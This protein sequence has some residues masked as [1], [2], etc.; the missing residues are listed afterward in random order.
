MGGIFYTPQKRRIGILVKI[1]YNNIMKLIKQEK[2]NKKIVD[3]FDF[4]FILDDDGLYLIEIIASAKSWWQNLKSFKS[5]L[6]DDDLA[7][8]LDRMEISTSSS[9]ETNARSVWHGNELKGF[10]KTVVTAIKL[11]KGKHTLSFT[12]YQKPYLKSI[13]ISQPEETDK[14]TYIP[15]DNNP[16][17]KGNGRPWLSFIL[18]NLSV[19]DL[20][21]SAKANKPDRDDDD[22][23]L[24]IDGETQK[25]S[26]KKSHQDWYWCGKTLKGEKKEFKKIVDY[27]GGMHTI[28]LW[29]DESPFLEKIELTLSNSSQY[30][31]NIIRPYTYK[32]VSGREDYNKFDETIALA[33]EHWNSEFKNDTDPPEK[34]LDP[35]LVKAIIF[36]ESR[37]GYDKEESINIMQVG[38]QGDASLKTLRGKLKEY[39]IHEGKKILLKYPDAQIDKEENS[40]KWGIRWLYHKA[41]GI[42]ADNRRY[43]LTWREAVKKYGPPN[44]KY[45]NNVWDIYTKG[46]DKRGKSPVRLWF[47][48]IP[49]MLVILSGAFWLHNNQGR[50]FISYRE[51]KHGSWL[52]DNGESW[53]DVA[54]IDDF[55]LKKARINKVQEIKEVCSGLKKGS[56]KYSYADLDNDGGYEIVLDGKWDYGNQVEYYLKIKKDELAIIP[57]NSS[58]FYGGP[59]SL[60]KKAVY[61]NWPDEQGK[62]TFAAEAVVGYINGP[63]KIFRDLYR[64]ND[65]GEIDLFRRETEELTSD[66]SKFGTIAE[67]PL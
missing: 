10:L 63:D 53:V 66:A 42:T 54:V 25:N 65:K 14:I 2:L 22:I 8:S 5:L 9:N 56:L 32:G 11:K 46:V 37:M 64:F 16:A 60:V 17:Q 21:V 52:C 58:F 30:N 39:W 27:N 1:L 38:V 20:F 29:A 45:S 51:A 62:Y 61:L 13:M 33:T 55:K 3:K 18:I 7:L 31:E 36:Q 6:N 43:W 59:E 15:V 47:I 24:I 28:D 40:I 41:M 26:D 57:V 44:E 23:K 48:F 67:M 50:V 34:T 19:K 35:N 4:Y 12:P 49:L